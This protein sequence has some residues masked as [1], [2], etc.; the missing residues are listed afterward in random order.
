MNSQLRAVAHI[1]YVNVFIRARVGERNEEGEREM[2][3]QTNGERKRGLHI[4]YIQLIQD[5]FDTTDTSDVI[6]K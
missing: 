6:G 2:K 4:L 3:R 1:I 5:T